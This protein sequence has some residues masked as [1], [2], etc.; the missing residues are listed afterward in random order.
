MNN[1]SCC[2]LRYCAKQLTCINSIKLQWTFAREVWFQSSFCSRGNWDTEDKRFDQFTW[3]GSSQAE[4]WVQ[5]IHLDTPVLTAVL[6]GFHKDIGTSHS[7]YTWR[8]A[9]MERICRF[10]AKYQKSPKHILRTLACVKIIQGTDLGEICHWTNYLN[11]LS[12]SCLLCK[13]GMTI[14]SL[15]RLLWELNEKSHAKC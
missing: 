12:F 13:R 4:L 7:V 3:L 9:S 15:L 11:S 8:L 5:T 6:W 10:L 1:G 14:V 2:G